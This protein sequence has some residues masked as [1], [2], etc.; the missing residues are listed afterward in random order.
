MQNGDDSFSNFISASS[1]EEVKKEEDKSAKSEE[2]SFFNQVAPTEKEK[3]KLTKDSILA[4]YSNTPANNFNQFPP[5]T[6]M[7]YATNFAQPQ[8]N[9]GGFPVQG[10]FQAPSGGAFGQWGAPAQPT[11]QYPLQQNTMQFPGQYQGAHFGQFQTGAQPTFN[12]A[13]APNPFFSSN[14]NGIQQQ[15]A[16]LN[17][18]SQS[19]GTAAPTLATNIWQ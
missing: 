3:I 1:S 16:S 6:Q 5:P 9:F 19:S 10:N 18:N 11:Q 15:L 8:P 14:Q 4:L 17:L 13:Q 2:E 7:P 12:T